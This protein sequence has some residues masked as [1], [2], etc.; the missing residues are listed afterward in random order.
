MLVSAGQQNESALHIHISP[1]FWIS[2]P[3]RSAQ[4]IKPSSRC[5]TVCSH[6]FLFYT[7]YQQYICVQPHLPVPPTSRHRFLN[8]ARLSLRSPEEA[9]PV[10]NPILHYDLVGG[11]LYDRP[12]IKAK[13][14]WGTPKTAHRRNCLGRL[15]LSPLL[16][17]ASFLRLIAEKC[18][19]KEGRWGWGC[20]LNSHPFGLQK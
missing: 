11:F 7:Q 17:P 3:F 4:C 20:L 9:S 8:P 15:P 18:P 2:F 1:L 6:Y 14:S 13:R 10:T 19:E 5:Y 12:R 16:L